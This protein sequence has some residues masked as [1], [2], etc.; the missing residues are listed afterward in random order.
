MD[1]EKY[2]LYEFKNIINLFNKNKQQ[3]KEKLNYIL[4][5]PLN[6]GKIST[7]N[8]ID[9]IS[10]EL[11][12]TKRK[13]EL[14]YNDSI[15]KSCQRQLELFIDK[16]SHHPRFDRNSYR[17]FN[18][19]NNIKAIQDSLN[20][21]NVFEFNIFSQIQEEAETFDKIIAK[22]LLNYDKT[23]NLI[24]IINDSLINYYG[25]SV[26]KFKDTFL[27]S[28]IFLDD[29]KSENPNFSKKLNKDLKI[30]N[31]LIDYINEI[32]MNPSEHYHDYLLLFD[33]LN[34]EKDII[35]RE[36]LRNF[37]DL[38]KSKQ[39]SA[40]LNKR[41]ILD[42]LAQKLL[43]KQLLSIKQLENN[44]VQFDFNE[45]ELINYSKNYFN[46]GND[47]RIIGCTCKNSQNSLSIL[48]DILFFNNIDPNRKEIELL[49]KQENFKNVGI[50]FDSKYNSLFI[51]IVLIDEIESISKL[52]LSDLF[53][54]EL[55]RLRNNPKGFL[56]EFE[57]LKK[58]YNNIN[59]YSGLSDNLQDLIEYIKKSNPLPEIELNEDLSLCCKEYCNFLID[60]KTNN[61]FYTEDDELLRLRLREY[62]HGFENTC[63]F[64]IYQNKDISEIMLNL[65]LEENVMVN[66]KGL[67]FFGKHFKFYGIAERKIRD[68]SLLVIIFTDYIQ[69]S[70]SMQ[71]RL[72][73]EFLKDLDL[74]RIYPRAMIKYLYNFKEN[75]NAFYDTYK[76]EKIKSEIDKLADF[77]FKAKKLPPLEEKEAVTL[78]AEKYVFNIINKKKMLDE[79]GKKDTEDHKDGSSSSLKMENI[80][81]QINLNNISFDL[82]MNKSSP[83]LFKNLFIN[84]LELPLY[85]E[86]I[87][88]NNFVDSKKCLIEILLNNIYRETIFSPIYKLFG[89]SI[90]EKRQSL[91]LILCDEIKQKISLTNYPLPSK[92]RFIR[93][94]LIEDEET[95]IKNNFKNLDI[96]N[97]GRIYPKFIMDLMQKN[98]LVDKNIIYFTALQLIIYDNPEEAEYK[99][100]N[101]DTFIEYVRR[102]LSLL[103]LKENVILF[104]ILKSKS[105]SKNI[106]FDEFKNILIEQNFKFIESEAETIFNNICYPDHSISQ[107]RFLETMDAIGKMR[108]GKSD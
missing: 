102:T 73:S 5:N 71:E 44:N 23:N 13:N 21:F 107:R 82:K 49:F 70:S 95:E 39:S 77:L 61:H 78:I 51:M 99:G 87:S 86:H 16:H 19:V 72:K 28:V 60:P 8:F 101:L 2:F 100:I 1:E 43:S 4:S 96:S 62:V 7:K 83:D 74:L 105:K 36:K 50:A 81:N 93:P 59:R 90:N 11:D 29:F 14:L 55:K 20:K 97:K 38:L 54:R 31:L 15:S 66:K 10:E 3:L 24:S 84:D 69:P 76:Q 25:V 79:C 75:H 6:I 94:S 80:I 64:V 37:L 106:G 104:N 26:K 103:S 88:L 68:K 46:I 57:I 63:Q 17:K 9:S 56:P 45:K 18:E 108:K 22:L 91:F 34:I 40:P 32:R 12:K 48:N 33:T 42:E 52:N 30:D 89:I 47:F 85:I 53:I 67:I 27:L 98:Q 65:L 58:T 92:A 41:I 35:S